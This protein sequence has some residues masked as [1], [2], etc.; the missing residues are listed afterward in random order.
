M[1]SFIAIRSLLIPFFTSLLIQC[2]VAQEGNPFLSH[3][4]LPEG[5]SNQNWGFVQ[6]DNGIM[7][8]LNRKG[9]FSFDGLQWDNL[10]IQG[11]PIALAY[12][13]N[14]FFC[15]DRGVGY[16]QQTPEGNF[17]QHLLLE[18]DDVNYFHKFSELP[19]GL[20]VISP[21]TICKITTHPTIAIDT[22]YFDDS[23]EVFISDF[24]ELN[25][26]TFHVKNRALIYR[27][28]PDEGYELLAGL[29]IGI[30]MT[31]SF[32]HG[33]YA[34]FGS[35]NNTLYRFNGERL[36]DVNIK[37]QDYITASIPTSGTS[38]DHDRFALATLNGGCVVINA[39]DGST[40][41]T[42]NYLNGLP[43]DE[44]Y[45]LGKDNDGGLWL[46]HGM[47]ISRADLD[48]PVKSYGHYRGLSGNILSSVIYGDKLYVGSSEGLYLLDEKRDYK[49]ISV[50]VKP[51]PKK[52]VPKEEPKP[53]EAETI[54]EKKRGFLYRL[55][56][57][58][59]K[60]SEDKNIQSDDIAE[61]QQAGQPKEHTPKRRTIYQLQ[62]VSHEFNKVKGVLGKVKQLMVY[63][64]KLYAASNFGLFEIDGSKVKHIVKDLNIYFVDIL[65]NSEKRFIIGADGGA[66]IV[67]FSKGGW[68]RTTILQADNLLIASAIQ[69]DANRFLL[70]NEFDVLLATR[71]E[72]TY[73]IEEVP[74]PNIE[75][76]DPVVRWLND[77]PYVLCSS[78]AFAFDAENDTLI[79]AASI[80][81]VGYSSLI[82]NQPNCTWLKNDGQWQLFSSS[83][84][85]S[86]VKSGYI[87][88]LDHPNY[89]HI[90]GDSSLLVINGFSQIYKIDF[91]RDAL[92]DDSL[93]IFFK[94]IRDREGSL[95]RHE[96]IELTYSN[97]SV[98]V[99]ISA[100]SYVKEGSVKFQYKIEGLMDDWAQWSSDPSIQFPFLP[101]GNHTIYIRARDVL[102]N[103][104]PMLDFSIVVKPPF[105]QT[106]WFYILC[107]VTALILFAAI[108]KVRERSLRREKEVL[109]QKV[110]ERTKTIE[111]QKEILRQQRDDLEVYNKEILQ[112]KAEIE[113]QRDEIEA[114]RDQIFK[115]NEE[116]T[117]SIAYARRIQSA[118]MPSNEIIGEILPRY[119]ILFRPRDIV[120]GD[121]YWIGQKD[122]LTIVVAADCTGH[123]V[124]GA[125]MSMMGVS[126]INDIV[127][128]DGVVSPNLI[129]EN[130]RQKIIT[131]LWQ[132]GKEGESQDGMDMAV[133]VYSKDMRQ[134]QFS[135]AYNPL[136][137]IR[138]GELIEYKAD[139]MPVGVHPKQDLVFST[140][141]IDLL[142]G[143]NL[144]I[145]SDGFV[146]QF[147]GPDGRKFM[148]KPFKQLL[149]SLEGLPPAEQ[150]NALEDALD[151]W[152][153]AFD[154]VDDVLIIGIQVS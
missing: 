64:G 28:K 81:V 76:N 2:G 11:R 8:V 54:E 60:D 140:H 4:S 105:W 73:E 151:K 80:P 23:P 48:I 79:E 38:V 128:V 139:K 106:I 134:V 88:L 148:T 35:T 56:N 82:F 47:G 57:R 32:I 96:N 42:L 3:Y 29:P 137:I 120:S 83:K 45:S 100:P 43:D 144:Y 20:F 122:G 143:D 10:G 44:I 18:S 97:N 50:A 149:I 12:S 129:L 153:N 141:T 114:Q 65:P 136:Y 103:V 26:N 133:C 110:R 138:S 72:S 71:K 63:N 99:K 116:I 9:I 150:R 117:Q 147:G 119:F 24:F 74:I 108:I 84:Q 132:T 142:P 85:G 14:V 13:K 118:V 146:D 25:G 67:D 31:Y 27:N 87:N 93:G 113:A 95:L 16:V 77:N 39:S 51:T 121:F 91:S 7:Y 92:A 37:D 111:E 1:K 90:Q 89:I 36:L 5:I 22:L 107:G 130:L 61:S 109:E 34:Y 101:P 123:G 68:R 94:S 69:L 104:S 112:Q 75:S 115:Q 55:F 17:S 131:T 78:G 49:A 52:T 40:S 66:Y 41:Y 70:T 125:F 135:G 62:S 19:D 102:G 152:Q 154:Q 30:D 33:N 15:T 126:F 127:N 46:S 6:G 53:K 21:T 58:R 86:T 145:F 59:S 98:R 124:P